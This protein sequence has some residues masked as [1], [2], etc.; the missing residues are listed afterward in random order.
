M[1]CFH[2][3]ELQMMLRNKFLRVCDHISISLIFVK[4]KEVDLARHL[5]GMPCLC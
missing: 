4:N 3:Q 1:L 2:T 5:N